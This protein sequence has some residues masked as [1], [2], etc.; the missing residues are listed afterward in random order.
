MN[1]PNSPWSIK[2]VTP[3]AR[4]AAKEGARISRQPLGK[5]LSEV[6]RKTS[7]AETSSSAAEISAAEISEAAADASPSTATTWQEAMVRLESRVA[8]SERRSAAAVEPV[9]DALD[10]L[11]ARL[12]SIETYVL[13]R[14]RRSY[15]TR[16]LRR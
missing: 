3:E 15:L 5:W 1:K 4:E 2:S 16:L 8:A 12:D 13:G 10:R 7:S 11:V 14:P 6:I 9:Q